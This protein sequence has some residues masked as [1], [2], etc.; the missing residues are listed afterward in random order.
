[1]HSMTYGEAEVQVDSSVLDNGCESEWSASSCVPFIPEERVVDSHRIQSMVTSFEMH[2][3][4]GEHLL[5]GLTCYWE[6]CEADSVSMQTRA[7]LRFHY[8]HNASAYL[9]GNSTISKFHRQHCYTV[10]GDQGLQNT[11]ASSPETC[12]SSPTTGNKIIFFCGTWKLVLVSHSLIF[13]WVHQA[14][15]EGLANFSQFHKYKQ[16]ILT[17][18]HSITRTYLLL[19]SLPNNSIYVLS[20]LPVNTIR[21]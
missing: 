7:R 3:I 6:I 14:T 5:S 4:F 8:D 18:A 17:P 15:T 9:H 11:V 20:K 16:A 2:C 19:K 13:I 21:W 12:W 1:M 10:D